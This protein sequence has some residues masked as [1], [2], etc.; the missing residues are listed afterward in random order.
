ML[1]KLML[2]VILLVVT[3]SCSAPRDNVETGARPHPVTP[4]E[5][6]PR[7]IALHVTSQA[8]HV[9][10]PGGRWV[11]PPA[12]PALH[13]DV[14]TAMVTLTVAPYRHC[15][16]GTGPGGRSVRYVGK[17]PLDGRPC[18][19]QMSPVADGPT[20]LVGGTSSV[21]EVILVGCDRCAVELY[22]VRVPT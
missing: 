20:Y 16:V 19:R 22:M 12:A 8:L 18:G 14:G 2:L 4:T 11:L 1:S 17:F 6:P 15:W 21:G 9:Q 13:G 5:D 7:A 10:L 3:C